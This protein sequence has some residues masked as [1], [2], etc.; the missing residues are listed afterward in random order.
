MEAA[1]AETSVYRRRRLLAVAA[2]ETS[3]YRRR[4][5][6]AVAAA[7]TSVCRRRRLL[8]AAAAETTD[9]GKDAG[10]LAVICSLG[11]DVGLQAR[12]TKLRRRQF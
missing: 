8:A 2:A 6:L 7:E 5:L 12:T 9:A 1:A 11:G 10:W 3:V 4:R